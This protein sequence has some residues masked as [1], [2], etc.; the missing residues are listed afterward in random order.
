MGIS[1]REQSRR[2]YFTSLQNSFLRKYANRKN[3]KRNTMTR[4]PSRRRSSCIGSP[5]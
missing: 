3:T 4:M 5:M 1:V 2:V